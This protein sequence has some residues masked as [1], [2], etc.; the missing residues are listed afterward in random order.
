[1][2]LDLREGNGSEP[3]VEQLTA[4]AIKASVNKVAEDIRRFV[5]QAKEMAFTLEMEGEE[6]AQGMVADVSKLA[7][8]VHSFLGQ[9]RSASQSMHT[10]RQSL[11]ALPTEDQL[12]AEQNGL[13][14][15]NAVTADIEQEIKA[16]KR[17]VS[18]A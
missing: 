1:M 4:E 6:Q 13:K 15:I 3:K 2:S 7:D 17:A 14:A 9:C 5:K 16:P 11:T 18:A 8:K 12:T 10:Y